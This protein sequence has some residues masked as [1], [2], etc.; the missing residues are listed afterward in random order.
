MLDEYGAGILVRNVEMQKVDPPEAVIEAFRDVQRARADQQREVNQAEGYRRDILPR[1]RGEA[2]RIM[3]EAQAYR[4]E[5]I[6]AAEGDAQRFLSVY[7]EYRQAKVI[8][9]KRIYLE[10]M[11]GI[12][13]G[14][15]KII[16]DI[17]GSGVLPYLPLNELQKS[18][19]Q[20]E[21]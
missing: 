11:E 12:L 18:K 6:A 16:V 8:T 21:N 9:R 19:Q 10:T 2:E 13:A 5:R 17:E 3:Q 4:Q 20:G 1:A 7:E 14:M 15:D